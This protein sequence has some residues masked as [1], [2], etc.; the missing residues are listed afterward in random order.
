LV[1]A[2]FQNILVDNTVGKESCQG[3]NFVRFR[4][5]LHAGLS[6]IN[7]LPPHLGYSLF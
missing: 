1:C 4:A 2:G 5:P 7:F 3:D 6:R